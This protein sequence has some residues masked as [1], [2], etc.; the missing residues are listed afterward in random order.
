MCMLM[1]A[2][3]T[4]PN[5]DVRVHILT[6]T[7][8]LSLRVSA[9]FLIYDVTCV[10]HFHMCMLRERACRMSCDKHIHSLS[11]R[12]SLKNTFSLSERVNSMCVRVGND[13]LR[14]RECVLRE[15]ECVLQ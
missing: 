12:E 14:E 15:R 4:N 6:R 10:S 1:S 13:S 8:S 9:P 2:Y 11:L 7:H 3:R 5:S